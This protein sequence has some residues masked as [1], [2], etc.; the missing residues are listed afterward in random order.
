MGRI[1]RPH[2]LRGEATVLPDSDDPDRFVVGARF[3]TDSGRELVVATVAPYRDRG[4][5]IAFEGIRSREAIEELRGSSLLIEP[6]QR[7][8]LV[9]GEFWEEQ[10]IGLTAVDPGGDVL[11]EV[12][13]VDLGPSQDRLVVTTGEGTEVLVPF[14]AGIVGDPEG[15]TITVDPPSGLFD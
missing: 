3:T 4:L 6:S 5:R 1:G 11:G 2:G 9:E 14:V 8:P 13:G 10:L 12:T 15:S 7:R